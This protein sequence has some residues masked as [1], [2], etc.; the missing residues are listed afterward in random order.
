MIQAFTTIFLLVHKV[1]KQ[2]LYDIKFDAFILIVVAIALPN[3]LGHTS[4]YLDS[5]S[6]TILTRIPWFS[7]IDQS[8]NRMLVRLCF[9]RTI[10]TIIIQHLCFSLL[11]RQNARLS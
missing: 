2:P 3:F 9:P 10:H 8:Q 1:R 4:I 5:I 6:S 11:S 7:L